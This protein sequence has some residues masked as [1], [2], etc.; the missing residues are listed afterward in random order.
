MNQPF[1]N[2]GENKK[3]RNRTKIRE[4][5]RRDLASRE[6]GDNVKKFS[7]GRKC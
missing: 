4:R 1:K 5:E 7:D 3:E 6:R 2:F